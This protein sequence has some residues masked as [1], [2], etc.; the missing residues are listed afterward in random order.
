VQQLHEGVPTVRVRV[1]EPPPQEAEHAPQSLQGDGTQSTGGQAAVLQLWVSVSAGHAALRT[2]TRV[3][4]KS[5]DD[6]SQKNKK[7]YPVPTA[8]CVMVRVRI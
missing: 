6:S 3:T 1:C 7:T 8:L 4:S 5:Q 2:N